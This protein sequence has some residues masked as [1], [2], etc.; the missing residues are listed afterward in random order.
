MYLHPLVEEIAIRLLSIGYTI[1]L[2]GGNTGIRISMPA[3]VDYATLENALDAAL[4]EYSGKYV[5]C[6]HKNIPSA[7]LWPTP[8]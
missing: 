4:A 6:P 7:D 8:Q 5:L 2:I 1:N 3:N